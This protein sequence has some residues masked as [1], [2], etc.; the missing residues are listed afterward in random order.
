MQK[1]NHYFLYAVI[2]AIIIKLSLF[3]F[4]EI[5]I[6]I[7]KISPDSSDY[8]KTAAVMASDGVFAVKDE[9]GGLKYDVLRTPGYPLFLAIF[10]DKMRISLGGIVFLQILLTLFAAFITY[11]TAA[12]LNL[13][14]AVLSAV[15]ILYDPPITIFSQ[16]IL[17][18]ALFLFL[19]ALFMLEFTRYL[20][21]RE[22]KMAISAALILV[23]A[24]YV[25]PVSYYLGIAMA[26][27]IVYANMRE[28]LKKGLIH[29]VIFFAIVYS[30]IGAWQVRNYVRC[31]EGVF[32]SISHNHVGSGLIGSYSRNSDPATRGMAPV[33]YYPNVTFRCLMSIMTRPGT[34]KDFHSDVLTAIGKV[35]AYPWMVFWLTGFIA[36][37]AAV[38]RNI[39]LQAYLFIIL[40]F[41]AVSIISIMW[42]VSERFRVPIMPFIAIISAYGWLN[43]VS[44][45][46]LDQWKL[47]FLSKRE[48]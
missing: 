15:I 43:L 6:P 12:S 38:K 14:I 40:Y 25:R 10:H 22:I 26:V 8:L 41:L 19:I 11:K 46:K 29:A 44:A 37:I 48:K 13:R 34:L 18:E 17:T 45:V 36:G 42:L 9:N 2:A 23:A 39:Y 28:N 27:F 5:H 35:L 31:G 1:N 47:I 7:S 33:L 32:S 20:K 4:A 24:T 3:A 21:F 30:L 16:M